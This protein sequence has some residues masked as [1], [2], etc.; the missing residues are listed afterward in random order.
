MGFH[1]WRKPLLDFLEHETY[2]TEEMAPCRSS[3]ERFW[4]KTIEVNTREF[5]NK[6]L[7]LPED[8]EES[9]FFHHLENDTAEYRAYLEQLAQEEEERREDREKANQKDIEEYARIA[10]RE[11]RR[12]NQQADRNAAAKRTGG[13]GGGGGPAGGYGS[14]LLVVSAVCVLSYL[15]KRV[16]W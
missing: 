6:T 13:A 15:I 8:R 12:R 10:M 2:E 4:K 7:E 3:L 9:V 16:F 11:Q 5:V 1:R 14:I